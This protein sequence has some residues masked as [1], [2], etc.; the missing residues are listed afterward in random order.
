MVRSCVLVHFC[1]TPP[2]P[3]CKKV[4]S[5]PLTPCNNLAFVTGPIE[6]AQRTTKTLEPAALWSD[7]KVSLRKTLLTL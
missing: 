1:Y 3:G 6:A 4:L 5:Y 2:F 7:D